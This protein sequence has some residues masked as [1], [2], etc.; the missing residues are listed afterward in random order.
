VVAGLSDITSF[1]LVL[2]YEDVAGKR[3]STRAKYLSEKGAYVDL[4]VEAER[5]SR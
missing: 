4:A 3:W 2:A 1:D 5:P